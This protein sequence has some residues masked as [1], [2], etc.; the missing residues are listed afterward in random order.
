[1]RRIAAAVAL[2]AALAVPT[3]GAA[4]PPSLPAQAWFA[5]GSLDGAVLA[6]S[7]AGAPRAVASITKLMTVLVALEHARLEDAVV[8]SP[9]ATSIGESSLALR[10]GERLTVRELSLGALVPSANDAATALALHVG[11]GS[12]PRF[13]ALMNAKARQLGLRSTRYRNPHGLD[14]PGHTSSA[15]D[16]VVLLRAALRVPF[17]ARALRLETVTIAGDRVLESTDRLLGEL[18]GFLGGKTGHTSAAGWSQVGAA[19]RA[20]VTVVASVLGASTEE[21]RDAALAR[22]LR[23][24]L[25]QYRQVAVIAAG[26]TY[27]VA[28]APYGRPAVRLVAARA[29]VRPAHLGRPLVEQVVVPSVVS[30]PVASGQRLGTVRVYDGERLVAQS[31]LVAADAVAA[32]GRFGK[33]RWYATRTLHHLVGLVS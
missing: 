4:P 30:L 11:R 24:S 26:R 9:Q 17:V 6:E 3:A 8:V 16:A 25:A 32:P 13:V 2:L 23:W 31:P 18:P 15:R 20:G 27:A 10:A 12:L 5:D 21:V 33:I 7:N 22:L 19:R 14:E 1:M 29:V 28:R